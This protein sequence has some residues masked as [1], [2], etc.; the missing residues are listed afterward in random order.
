[1]TEYRHIELNNEVTK[2]DDTGFFMLYKDKEAISEFLREVDDKTVKFSSE[3]KRLKYLVEENFYYNIFDKYIEE[4][5]LECIE[6]A[7][8]YKFEFQSYM[9]AS[10][11]YKDYALKTNDKKQYLE[12]YNQHV[13]IVALYL[14]NGDVNL[15]KE[16]II[17][18]LEQRVQPATPTF[19]NAGRSRRG[20]LVSCFL[21]EVG[22]SLNSIN[23]IDSTA[24]QLSKI[25][26]GV[27]INLSKLR[28]RG[29]SIKGIKGV[30]KGV[31]PVA[32][33]L[34]Q[35]FAY[36]DQLGQRPGAGAVYLNIFH[37][38]VLEFLDTKKV[39]ADEELR[40]PTISTG[41]IV[42]SLFFKLAKENKDFYMFG[43]HSIWEEY[44]LVLDDIDI[45]KYYD[46]FV[47]NE[48]IIKRAYGARDMLSLIASTQLQSG[49]PYLMFKDNANKNHALQDI[50]QVKMSNLCTEIFQLQETSV[51]KDY[52]EGDIIKRDISCNLASLNIVNVME[53]KKIKESVYSGMDALTFVSNSTKIKNAPGV[54][55]ANDEFHS[56]GLGAMNLHGYLAKNLIA[57]ESEEA[58]DFANVFFMMM[59]YYTLEKSML[60]AKERKETFKD[61]EKSDYYNGK[62]FDKYITNSYLPKTEKVKALFEGIEIPTKDNWLRLK[63]KVREHGVYHAYR[64]AIAPTQSI[65]YVQNSTSSVLPIV[66]KIERRTYGNAETF[67]PMP[68]LSAKT[69]WYYKSAFTIDQMKLIDLMSVIQ[70]HIDQGISI[71]LYVNSDISTRELAKY[72]VYA[73]HKGLKSLYY[74]RNKLLSVEECTSCAV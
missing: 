26:G 29:E 72:Y 39:N 49:Y 43:P 2:R 8:N 34:E 6:L 24:K 71:I 51:I 4:E 28:A 14:A 9:A 25:G 64:M 60:I 47:A 18:M 12:N 67:Y 57:Y 33:S 42:P 10:K 73:H 63:N 46:E 65:S 5:I 53:S 66:D 19:L 44:G 52:G 36:A 7:N 23:Y 41:L 40:L 54:V 61:F 48:N 15:A 45:E 27:A 11:F 22:D 37:Y 69:Q 21:L 50:G 56:V 31:I 55:K 32:K 74:T 70:E 38:D 3:L 59:N 16:L 30:A 62:Y 1:M 58:K 35:G 20:E 17:A 68:Y 13:F